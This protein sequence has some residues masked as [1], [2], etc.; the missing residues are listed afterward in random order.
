[1]LSGGS[2]NSIS[3]VFPICALRLVPSQV[4]AEGGTRSCVQAA[5][6][7]SN[8]QKSIAPLRITAPEHTGLVFE[9]PKTRASSFGMGGTP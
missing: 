4:L 2:N 9:L 8:P 6:S 3:D 7:P 5:I 1:M